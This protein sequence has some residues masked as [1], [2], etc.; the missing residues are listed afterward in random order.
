MIFF[1]FLGQLQKLI[2]GNSQ[3]EHVCK[4]AETDTCAKAQM[5]NCDVST[6]NWAKDQV[7]LTN[8]SMLP[9]MAVTYGPLTYYWEKMKFT[10]GPLLCS[11][12]SYS[13]VKNIYDELVGKETDG[14][15]ENFRIKILCFANNFSTQSVFFLKKQ[16]FFFSIFF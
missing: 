8:K 13:F 12:I 5:C 10:V 1:L 11:G 14:R 16:L 15:L 2:H 4:C 6:P 3:L 9:V 7:V